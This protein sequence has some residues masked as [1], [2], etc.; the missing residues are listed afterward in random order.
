M[1]MWP[2]ESGSVPNLHWPLWRRTVLVFGWDSVWSRSNENTHTLRLTA[3]IKRLF[4]QSCQET[5][6][7]RSSLSRSGSDVFRIRWWSWSSEDEDTFNPSDNQTCAFTTGL[8]LSPTQRL[9]PPVRLF[10][11]WTKRHG[12]SFCSEHA[13]LCSP[14]LHQRPL[15]RMMFDSEDRSPVDVLKLSTATVS[16]FQWDTGRN[17]GHYHDSLWSI[18]E[19][20]RCDGLLFWRQLIT[21]LPG[22]PNRK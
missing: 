14:W 8:F 18:F 13:V 10:V 12:E 21:A 15:D 4:H 22:R 19:V 2:K 1:F 17:P 20:F 9:C 5:L 6:K 11:T 3:K 16:H 7:R